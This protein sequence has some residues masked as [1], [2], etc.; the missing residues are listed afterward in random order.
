MEFKDFIKELKKY[1]WL[2]IITPVLGILIAYFYN[3]S[4]TPTYESSKL[5]IITPKIDKND[6]RYSWPVGASEFTDNL[7]GIVGNT[8]SEELRDLKNIE[9][10]KIGPSALILTALSKN[11]NLSLEKINNAKKTIDEQIKFYNEGVGFTFVSIDKGTFFKE[12]T[13]L[14]S[15][16][17]N[18]IVGAILGFIFSAIIFSIKLFIRNYSLS[19]VPK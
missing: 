5:I 13:S 17:I 3:F 18:L 2:F 6:Q 19:R 16:K 1:F 8:S 10:K 11:K 14:N 12:K 9:I 4:W 15:P 7:I